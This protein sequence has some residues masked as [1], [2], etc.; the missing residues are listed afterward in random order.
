M[1]V[2]GVAFVLAIA[3]AVAD[4]MDNARK[5]LNNCLIEEHNKAVSAKKTAS[6][7][8]TLISTACETERTTYHSFIVK[9]ERGFGSKAAEAEAYAKDEVQAVVDSITSAFGPNVESNS[10]MGKEK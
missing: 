6:E 1:F 9:A 3:S 4:P 7:F 2:Y 8:L 10:L 5:A